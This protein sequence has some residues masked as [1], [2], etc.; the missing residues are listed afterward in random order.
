MRFPAIRLSL[1]LLVLAA[2]S[3]QPEPLTVDSQDP[4]PPAVAEATAKPLAEAPTSISPSP[5]LIPTETENSSTAPAKLLFTTYPGRLVEGEIPVIVY[6]PE[7]FYGAARQYPV[8]YLLHGIGYDEGMWLDFGIR[9]HVEQRRPTV[10]VM[11]FIPQPLLSQTDGGSNS[12]EAELMEGLI[13][14]IE[15]RFGIDVSSRAIAGISRGAVWALEI[16][17]RHPMEFD[18]V[19]ALSP[20]LHL[21]RP[22]QEYDPYRVVAEGGPL[23]GVILLMAGDEE[24]QTLAALELLV[25][26][27]E[28]AD[29]P[30]ELVIDEGNHNEALWRLQIDSVLAAL[31]AG[32]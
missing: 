28:K 6:L 30:F 27:L 31:T 15:G 21:N 11:P 7:D 14:Q 1:G 13:P 26:E 12:Y 4:L 10:L 2:C 24:R 29:T 9:T 5:S 22:R 20:S 23:P 19:A 18:G 17:F 3:T 8:I 16:A 25:A 32:S